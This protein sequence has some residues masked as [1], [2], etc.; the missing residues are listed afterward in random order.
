MFK[1]KRHMRMCLLMDPE[2]IYQ[3]DSI[4]LSVESTNSVGMK[5][6]GEIE[7]TV[8][9]P[10]LPDEAFKSTMFKAI[11]TEEKILI[12]GVP[13]TGHFEADEQIASRDEANQLD[14]SKKETA[15]FCNRRKTCYGR[16]KCFH[17]S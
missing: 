7:E 17:I 4:N 15:D 10:E 16:F 9:I 8:V 3:S 5:P 1:L 6:N 12:D 13:E 14:K 11:K 2:H